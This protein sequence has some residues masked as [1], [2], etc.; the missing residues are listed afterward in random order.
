M[1]AVT[2]KPVWGDPGVTELL[3]LQEGA[4]AYPG[5]NGGPVTRTLQR[6]GLLKRLRFLAQYHL[7]VTVHAGGA[8]TLSPYGPLGSYINN[9]SVVANGQIP[10]VQLS[11]L[12][13]TIYNEVENRDGSIIAYAAYGAVHQVP[14]SAT[15][16]KFD[17]IGAAATGDF[18]GQYPF[19]FQFA[20]PF[21]I[22]QSMQELGLWLLQNQAIDVGITVNFNTLQTTAASN[23]VPWSGVV[24][25]G[26]P[27]LA[28]CQVLIERELYNIPADPASY[29]N[30]MWA[31]QVIEFV[32]PFTGKFSR[33]S[34]PRA[35]LLLRVIVINLDAAS[36]AAVENTDVATLS[37]IY[38]SNETPVAR[39]GWAWNLEFL[40]DYNRMPPKG[41]ISFDPYKF[42]DNGLKLVKSTEDLAN[43]RIETSFLTQATGSQ[44]IIL[45]RLIPV[46]A[47]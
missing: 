30:L 12:G 38:G 27:T 26:T 42:G 1:A 14:S 16:I 23:D 19:E 8:E 9:I 13:A 21:N 22:S 29:P 45:D 34:I 10:L 2:N 7:N 47:R 28:D 11:G 5:A 37:Y 20:L 18:Y 3:Q 39:P 32:V 33:F 43:L 35:G 36:G 41:V 24:L 25:T 40:Q 17:A 4:I 44:R 31:H 6:A 46:S 15:L